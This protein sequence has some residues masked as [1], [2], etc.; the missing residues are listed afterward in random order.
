MA[1]DTRWTD[2]QRIESWAGE[3][4]VNL[5]R[6]LALIGFYGHHLI[7]FYLLRDDPTIDTAYHLAVTA[8]VLA[9]SSG[10]LALHLCLSRRWA[11][12]GLKYAATSWDM[13]LITA[14]LLIGKDA[15]TTLPVLY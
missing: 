14:L 6:L 12:S 2:A 4:R 11:P 7:N 5:I 10:V 15:R 1:A 3:V 13:V 9:W 8:L